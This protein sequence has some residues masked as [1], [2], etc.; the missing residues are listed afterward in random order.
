MQSAR[1]SVRASSYP[2]QHRPR[3]PA[4][5]RSDCGRVD[6][7]L[8]TVRLERTVKLAIGFEFNDHDLV[9][10]DV[11]EVDVAFDECT[12]RQPPGHGVSR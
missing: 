5:G 10:H 2:H 9:V 1:F 8:P 3:S 12:I 7:D 4:E 11:R 6:L